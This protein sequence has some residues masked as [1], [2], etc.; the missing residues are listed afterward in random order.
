[1]SEATE[2]GQPPNYTID[3]MAYDWNGFKVFAYAAPRDL[4][5]NQLSSESPGLFIAITQASDT[6]PVC[7]RPVVTKMTYAPRED[8]P[9]FYYKPI[10]MMSAF[11]PQTGKQF[12]DM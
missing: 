1:M 8:A 11:D 3:V 6:S 7:D 9:L 12:N 5:R 4:E 2:D 10:N